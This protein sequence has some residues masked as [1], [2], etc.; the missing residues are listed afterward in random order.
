MVGD[1]YEFNC[2]QNFYQINA[3]INEYQLKTLNRIV[4]KI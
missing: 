3:N 1:K 4:F 2:D